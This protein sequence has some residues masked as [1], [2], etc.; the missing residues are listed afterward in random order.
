LKQVSINIS[1]TDVLPLKTFYIHIFKQV[2][3]TKILNYQSAETPG[4]MQSINIGFDQGVKMQDSCSDSL[5]LQIHSLTNSVFSVIPRLGNT[6][7]RNIGIVNIV[8]K[9]KKR[10]IILYVPLHIIPDIIATQYGF[11]FYNCFYQSFSYI[12]PEQFLPE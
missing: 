7:I 9:K 3:S 2:R 1:Q 12:K 8:K 6:E 11:M 4:T 5:M 10:S